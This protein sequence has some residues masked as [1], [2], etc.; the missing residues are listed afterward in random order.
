ME[1]LGGTVDLEFLLRGAKVE[2]DP[3]ESTSDFAA[4]PERCFCSIGFIELLSLSKAIS[5]KESFSH[6]ICTFQ[7][8][9]VSDYDVVAFSMFLSNASKVSLRV[10]EELFLIPSL[11]FGRLKNRSRS[12][13]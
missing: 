4:S 8:L 9:K 12:W 5:K 1:P 3:Q 13:R 7:G 11:R 6:S 2:V 10:A